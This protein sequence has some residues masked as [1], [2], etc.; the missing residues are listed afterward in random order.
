M[1]KVMLLLASIVTV[2]VGALGQTDLVHPPSA[3]AATP[4]DRSQL[5]AE[6]SDSDGEET[7]DMKLS[8]T[9]ETTEADAI[10]ADAEDDELEAAK[11]MRSNHP[12]VIQNGR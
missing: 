2:G 6:A 1:S 8:E 4:V 11:A 9:T 3:I 12:S 10:D 5:A 7:D